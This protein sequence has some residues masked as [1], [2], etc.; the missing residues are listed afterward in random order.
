MMSLAATTV[1]IVLTFGTT[2]IIDRKKQRDDKRETLDNIR[3]IDADLKDF[4]VLQV[5]VV[6]HPEK[7]ED[8]FMELASKVPFADYATTAETIFRSSME[9]MQTIGSILFIQT[10]SSIPRQP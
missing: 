1:S 10:V 9:T 2:A 8:S 6:A 3:Q 7:L 5:D 4:F